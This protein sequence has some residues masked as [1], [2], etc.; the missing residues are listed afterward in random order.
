MS[1]SSLSPIGNESIPQINSL[2]SSPIQNT[3]FNASLNTSF[4]DQ[5]KK[6]RKFQFISDD[7]NV[8]KSIASV[9]LGVCVFNTF[10]SLY[11][12]MWVITLEN[13]IRTRLF[14]FLS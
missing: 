6:K 1:F 13:P 2:P 8:D 4:T 12:T 11:S 5:I 9:Y 3:S 7:Q 14:L 10:V